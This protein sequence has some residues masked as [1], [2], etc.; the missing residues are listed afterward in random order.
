MIKKI[1]FLLL[2]IPFL[3]LG[4]V[5]IGTITPNANA[6]LE[7]SSSNQGLLLPRL[8][9]SATTSPSPLTAHVSGMLVY[10]LV[11]AGDVTPGF[12]YN[13]GA[14]WERVAT[15]QTGTE[16]NLTGNAGTNS[17]TNF[18]GTTDNQ[19]LTFRV[20]NV[21]KLRLETNGTISTLNTG[22]SVFIGNNA[23]ANDDLSNNQ[24]VFIGKDAGGQNTTGESNTAVGLSALGANVTGSRNVAF[25]LNSLSANTDGND[26]IAIGD[27]ALQYGT[28]VNENV[29]IGNQSFR[30]TT[31]GTHN[32]GIGYWSGEKNTTGSD[33]V[34]IGRHALNDNTTG[35]FNTAIGK[36]AYET[37]SFDNSTAIGHATS[38]NGNNRVHLGDIFITQIRG[39]VNFSTYSDGRIKKN[40]QEDVVGLD[41]ITKLRPVT[42][43]L[44]TRSQAK[45]LGKKETPDYES[46][47][48]I[49]KI[50][51]SGFIAQEVEAAASASNYDFSGVKTPTKDDKLYAL[52]YAEFVVP[53]VKAVQEQ[54]EMIED[55]EKEIA[56]LKKEKAKK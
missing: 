51:M 39:E 34:A 43:N 14:N 50:K 10:N 4:Q 42:Y 22:N 23:G 20:N 49:E 9:L 5:G 1:Y 29:A 25:G 37:G 3:S 15:N 48:D 54:Q 30:E 26:N 17:A 56:L 12:Y 45:L 13:T 40:I 38:I 55:I 19:A 11:T 6:I 46:K 27:L 52:S 41:F 33:N 35:S 16:W 2:V 18:L 31:T 53:L 32:V 47:Y 24:N 8:N 21:E 7:I 36:D 28:S 44:D